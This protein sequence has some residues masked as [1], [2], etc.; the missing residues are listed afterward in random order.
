MSR[1]GADAPTVTLTRD[2]EEQA[3]M[4]LRAARSAMALSGLHRRPGGIINKLR[5]ILNTPVKAI[6]LVLPSAGRSRPSKP[7]NLQNFFL[8]LIQSTRKLNLNHPIF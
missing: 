4:S 1:A 8:A 5:Q 6:R 7:T 3:K 2:T